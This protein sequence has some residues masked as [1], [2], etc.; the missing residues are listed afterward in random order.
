MRKSC[1]TQGCAEAATHGGYCEQCH[2]RRE[3]SRAAE[4]GTAAERGYGY[5]WSQLRL[6]VLR[7]HPACVV[8]GAPATDVDHI[9]PKRRGG[10][11]DMANLQALCHS[12]HT[13]KTMRERRGE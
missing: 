13:R 12:C 4:R 9:T 10:R 7:A 5:R 8:C 2:S 1:L 11:D 6:M 3:Q